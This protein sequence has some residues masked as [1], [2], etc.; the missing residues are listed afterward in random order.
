M[1]KSARANGLTL[2]HHHHLV[3]SRGS[4][5]EIKLSVLL[6]AHRLSRRASCLRRRLRLFRTP[7]APSFA[8]S[9]S[10]LHSIMITQEAFDRLVA[11]VQGL[12][13]RVESLEVQLAARDR[14]ITR[15][16]DMVSALM[17]RQ[18][19]KTV[20]SR[21][22]N[23]SWGLERVSPSRLPRLLRSHPD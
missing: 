6:R 2:D 5:S 13:A 16:E 19:D 17:D 18:E 1:L 23:G 11:S 10:S 15:L 7:P 9:S 20:W 8:S 14:T 21:Q 12:Q 3:V 22:D 4:L